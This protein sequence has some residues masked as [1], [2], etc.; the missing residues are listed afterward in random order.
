M[1]SAI[2]LNQDVASEQERSNDVG[3]DREWNFNLTR[4]L[5]DHYITKQAI[6][7]WEGPK[8]PDYN[9]LIE[10]VCSFENVNWLAHN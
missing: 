1:N 6:N 8:Y 9:L 3:P 4:A 10:S 2:E 7:L 5:Q